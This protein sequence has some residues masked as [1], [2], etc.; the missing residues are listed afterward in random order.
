[1]VWIC[2]CLMTFCTVD[3]SL[4]LPIGLRNQGGRATISGRGRDVGWL[5]EVDIGNRAGL[6]CLYSTGGL[7]GEQKVQP[8]SFSLFT[9]ACDLG[10]FKP[11]VCNQQAPAKKVYRA[12]VRIHSYA[13]A[14]LCPH[15]AAVLAAA[16][17]LR[18]R[19]ACVVSKVAKA[20]RRQSFHLAS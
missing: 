17:P 7:L 6:R 15:C 8:S 10:K 12:G 20:T 3:S 14:P 18:R 9:P 5:K 13:C 2:L 16:K 11:S 4:A 19:V 1:M